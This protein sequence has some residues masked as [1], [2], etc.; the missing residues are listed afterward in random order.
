MKT[1]RIIVMLFLATI[2]FW[3]IFA[4][5]PSS[6]PPGPDMAAGVYI[7]AAYEFFHWEEGLN[8]MIWHN[9]ISSSSCNSS[10]STDDPVH[11]VECNAASPKNHQFDWQIKT[12]DGLT[13]EFT[14]NG[15]PIL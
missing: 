7:D 11:T 13:G 4:C 5:S 1:F 15:E 14:I 12:V 8:V 2:L 10:G 9:A 3:G 6:T